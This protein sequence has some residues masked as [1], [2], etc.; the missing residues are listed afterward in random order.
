MLDRAI[1]LAS[2]AHKGQFDK[3]GEPYILHP[4]R[5]M[6]DLRKDG[7]SE[8]YQTV[9]VLHD[10]V[11]DTAIEMDQIHDDFGIV[12]AAPLTLLTL[13]KDVPYFD[14]IRGILNDPVSVEVKKRDLTDN[15]D[16]RR[17]FHKVKYDK[18]ARAM[19]I[20]MGQKR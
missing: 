9:G 19:A 18:Y 1:A 6:M 15:T 3:Q 2:E 14:Y 13:E 12:I 11:E 8:V 20:L 17:F 5:V 16:F 7:F 4:I 10:V